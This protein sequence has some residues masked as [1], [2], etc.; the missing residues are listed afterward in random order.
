MPDNLTKAQR[1]HCMSRVRTAETDIE[2]AVAS[3]VRGLKL[4]FRRNDSRLP[5]KPDIV[6]PAHRL[7]IFVDGDFWHGYRF[8]QWC[9]KVSPFW[10][11]KIARNRRRDQRNFAKLRRLGWRPVRIWQHDIEAGSETVAKKL[12]VRLYSTT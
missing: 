10:R 3:V 4:R 5:G 8:P 1:S 2:N 12:R 6:V 9:H 7:A 11:T